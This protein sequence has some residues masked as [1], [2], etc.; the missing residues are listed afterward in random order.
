MSAKLWTKL[1]ASSGY[2]QVALLTGDA[3]SV[4]PARQA[5]IPGAGV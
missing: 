1:K 5:E 3:N 2:M 4:T